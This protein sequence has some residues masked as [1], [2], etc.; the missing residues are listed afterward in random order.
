MEASQ[1]AKAL[2]ISTQYHYIRHYKGDPK[3]PSNPQRTYKADWISWYNFLGNKEPNFY[4]SIEEASQAAIALGIVS[5]GQYHKH[6]KEDSKLPCNPDT[7]YK[8][9]WIN[10]K[11]FLNKYYCNLK[12]ASKAAKA[13]G[14][15][16]FSQYKKLYKKDPK[17]PCSPHIIYKDNWVNWYRFLG[18][19]EPRFYECIEEASKA[20]RAL[21]ISSGGQYK[22]RHKEDTKLPSS[23]DS[24]YK[25]DWKSWYEFLHT[26]KPEH[27]KTI[28]EASKATI[29][30]G[31]TSRAQYA[32]CN[33]KDPKLPYT[34]ERT[35][36]KEWDDFGKWYGYLGRKAPVFYECIEEASKAAIA[37]GIT[38]H[39]QYI[40]RYKEDPHLPCNPYLVYKDNWPGWYTFLNKTTPLTRN[41]ITKRY[42]QWRGWFDKYV[43]QLQRGIPTKK[44]TCLAFICRFIIAHSYNQQP[45]S[46]LHK[47]TKVSI[48]HYEDFLNSFGE[49][50]KLKFHI[51]VI[52]FLDYLL[53]KLCTIEDEFE[54][55]RH[56]DYRNP[57]IKFQS[58]L[59]NIKPTKLAESDKPV[60]AY[61]HV[62][63]AREWIIPPCTR[64]F[65]EL[66][67][68]FNITDSDWFDV[69][70]SL[71]DKS[72][73]DCVF[74]CI[75]RNDENRKNHRKPNCS[76]QK[77]WQIWSPVRWVV[78]FTLLSVPARG[79]QILWC[80]SGEGDRVIPEFVNG[81]IVWCT[82]T[83]PLAGQTEK[84]GMIK[85]YPDNEV[86]LYFTT[87][88]TAYGEDGYDIPWIPDGVEHWIIQLRRW[89]SKYNPLKEPTKWTSIDHRIEIGENILKQRDKNCFLFRQFGSV[90]P[91]KQPIFR[92]ALAYALHKIE[93]SDNRLTEELNKKDN[94]SSYS[95][96][97]T[98]HSMRVSLVTAFVVD[99]KVPIHI[100]QKL[101]GHSR[102]VMTIYYTKVSCAEIRDELS[103]ADKRALSKAPERIQRQIR[104]KKFEDVRNSFVANDNV[105]LSELNNSHPASAFSFTD[106]GICPMGGG[107]CEVGG[108]VEN[109]RAKYKKYLPV[110]AGY[111][112]EKN[113]IRCRFFITGPAFLGGLT[114]IFNEI[115]LKQ[116]YV[117]QKESVLIIHIEKLHDERYDSEKDNSLFTQTLELQRAESNLEIVAKEKSMYATESV[118]LLRLVNQCSALLNESMKK[119]MGTGSMLL[120]NT[121][122]RV[123]DWNVEETSSEFRQL[124][125]VCENATIYALSDASLANSRRSQL[126]DK[127]VRQN[128][129]EPKMYLLSSKQQLEVGNQMTELLLS[130]F[131][132]WE[133]VDKLINNEIYLDDLSED[134]KIVPVR[135]EIKRILFGKNDKLLSNN[136]K[137]NNLMQGGS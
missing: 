107:K 99:A 57:L 47:T 30:L 64:N 111:L 48:N 93:R 86:G 10:W 109:S 20:S 116:Q 27:Y 102:L 68:L 129:I 58:P 83:G 127:L 77:V 100:V 82:N 84:Q 101:V 60:L 124:S 104:N 11:R 121:T 55:C 69:D 4:G 2:G 17:L 87:N 18:N 21:G 50:H 75:E 97:Y 7:I 119:G 34:P 65:S 92:N 62:V 43:A 89:Q 63:A 131:K 56:P 94:L 59:L 16:Y 79:Q 72:D 24:Y 81:K 70:E 126:I 66:T 53:E 78:L 44:R 52:D 91:Y 29:A 133:N 37:L 130:R 51:V 23:P 113:C 42:E 128:G 13:L 6:Y 136:H 73:P 25:S 135:E 1:A 46:F 90:S 98:P 45:E 71:L 108:E 120:A 54:S 3:L 15:K 14:I 32:K 122:T 8:S 28:E 12:Q 26:E 88:K 96:D 67:H 106:I 95:T 31:I 112:G 38:S 39:P 80:D 110:T 74:R 132:S 35:Y 103:A 19:P 125:T 118:Y 115:S 123:I 76:N 117:S 41:D 49:K 22:K 137:L 105:F 85:K 40:K 114:S 134:E 5:S 33:Y 9:D 36:Q 61:T